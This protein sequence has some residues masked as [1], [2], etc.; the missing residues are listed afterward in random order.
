MDE[1]EEHDSEEREYDRWNQGL[2]D[3][4]WGTGEEW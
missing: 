4:E 3:E 1:R 2:D